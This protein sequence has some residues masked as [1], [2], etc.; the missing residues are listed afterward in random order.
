MAND[1]WVAQIKMLRRFVL[2]VLR[3]AYAQFKAYTLVALSGSQV[4]MF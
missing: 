4:E 3:V 2:R 1:P